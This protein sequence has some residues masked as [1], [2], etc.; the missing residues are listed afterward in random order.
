MPAQLTLHPG[1]LT[2]QVLWG[3]TRAAE[4]LCLQF[5]KRRRLKSKRGVVREVGDYAL[6]VQCPC[7]MLSADVI[8]PDVPEFIESRG[9][10][11][12]VR[13]DNTENGD[14]FLRFDGNASLRIHPDFASSDE[15]WRLFKP[16][17]DS[18]HLIFAGG[19]L[20]RE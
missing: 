8:F 1:V 16:G 3:A 6:H 12:V 13:V 17:R 4:T 11:T 7:E 2:E 18:A 14:F 5:G 10:L 19:Q 20:R 9:P 15:Q